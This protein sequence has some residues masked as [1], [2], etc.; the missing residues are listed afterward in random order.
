MTL[1]STGILIKVTEKQKKAQP[2]LTPVEYLEKFM[3]KR[4]KKMSLCWLETFFLKYMHSRDLQK[5]HE[6]VFYEKLCM[7]FNSFAKMEL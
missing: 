1:K 6:N 5:I 2:H 4:I 3:E 7:T